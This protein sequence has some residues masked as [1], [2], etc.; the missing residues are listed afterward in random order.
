[1]LRRAHWFGQ[2]WCEQ[3]NL[4]QHGRDA[5]APL[6][7]DPKP[8]LLGYRWLPPKR[9]TSVLTGFFRTEAGVRS[10]LKLGE[11]ILRGDFLG[12]QGADDGC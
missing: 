1:M 7:C 12:E 10:D 3:V 11:F 9:S 6:L 2:E 4:S 8:N 5:H